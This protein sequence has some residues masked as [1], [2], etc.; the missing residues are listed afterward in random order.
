M[1]STVIYTSHSGNTEEVAR[2]MAHALEVHGDVALIALDA[3]AVAE[4]PADT[5][6]LLMGGPTEQHGA[7]REVLAFFE[8]LGADRRVEGMAAAAFDT[9]LRW[10]HW[11]SG[12]AAEV[13]DERLRK[14]GARMVVEPES[15]IVSMKP[16]LEPGE[17]ER[18]GAWALAVAAAARLLKP[19]P[20][21]GG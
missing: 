12:S 21:G 10:P 19:A 1:K 16:L 5:D 11:L 8:E 18:A 4:I 9:R 17:L 2:A 14:A 20:A 13:I 6:L 15:F 7:T 3:E